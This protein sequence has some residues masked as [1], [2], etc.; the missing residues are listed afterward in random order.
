MT[1]YQSYTY[2]IHHVPTNTYYYGVRWQ[3]IRLKRT[4]EEDLW[5]HYFTR[6][7]K[8]KQLIS[9]YGTESFKFQIRKKFNSVKQ[10]RSW[11]TKVLKRMKVLS[12]PD[13]WLNRTDNKSILNETHPRGT[14]G[15]TWKN[16]YKSRPDKIGNHNTK[17][18]KWIYNEQEK[19]MISK[20]SPIPEGYQLGTGRTNKR[21]D[22]SEY[23]SKNN[24]LKFQGKPGRSMKGNLNPMFGKKH[25][26]LTK[27]K[28]SDSKKIQQTKD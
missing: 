14:L 28:I 17:G 11:E 20:D 4:P 8:V 3:N 18:T 10:A 13:I 7:K 2:L 1:I 15:K 26:D 23:N 19:R 12:K 9:E 24:K 6:S 27:K 21:P 5:I 22:L 25:S 16:E